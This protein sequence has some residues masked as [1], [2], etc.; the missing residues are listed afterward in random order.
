MLHNGQNVTTVTFNGETVNKI[1]YNG[2]VDFV[3]ESNLQTPTELNL[4]TTSADVPA[5]DNNHL[6]T[7]LVPQ[8]WNGG[9]TV[10][11]LGYY[12]DYTQTNVTKDADTGTFKFVDNGITTGSGNTAGVPRI[13]GPWFHTG[14]PDLNGDQ[15]MKSI[16]MWIKPDYS[17][18]PTQ[19]GIYASNY[20]SGGNGAAYNAGCYSYL[21]GPGHENHYIYALGLTRNNTTSQNMY[22]NGV[23]GVYYHLNQDATLPSLDDWTMITHVYDKD[24]LYFYRDDMLVGHTIPGPGETSDIYYFTDSITA[25]HFKKNLTLGCNAYSGGFYSSLTE[26]YRIPYRGLIGH[27]FAWSGKAINQY[28]VEQLYNDTRSYYDQFR[29]TPPLAKVPPVDLFRM[30]DNPDDHMVVDLGA[31]KAVRGYR[32]ILPVYDDTVDWNAAGMWPMNWTFEGSNDNSSWTVLDT[33]TNA[34]YDNGSSRYAGNI[35]GTSLKSMIT[36][37]TAY[38]YYRLNITDGPGG[39][40]NYQ[41]LRDLELFGF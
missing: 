24:K 22:G 7:M 21:F 5:N 40:S 11:N 29:A 37:T 12:G 38:R 26:Y 30:K 3:N 34:D 32:M 18:M 27:V 39:T 13:N 19:G 28:E 14:D 35:R 10:N 41:T 33:I 2:S 31:P 23:D 1:L 15:H 36:N 4:P 8:D 25:Q 20:R 17:E 16:S 9:A 6:T